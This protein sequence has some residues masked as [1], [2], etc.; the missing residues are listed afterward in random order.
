MACSAGVSVQK[1]DAARASTFAWYDCA[2]EEGRPRIPSRPLSLTR[3]GRCDYIV[4]SRI[5][6]VSAVR[7]RQLLDQI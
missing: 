3:E 7:S 5:R 1:C 6:P 4:A 2:H